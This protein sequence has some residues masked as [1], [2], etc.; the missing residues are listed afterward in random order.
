[1]QRHRARGRLVVPRHRRARADPELGLDLPR[2]RVILRRQLVG[3][4]LPGRRDRGNRVGVQRA[5]RFAPRRA[6]PSTTLQNRPG[7]SSAED[8]TA[9]A[10][11]GMWGLATG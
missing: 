3:R 7:T 4:I 10:A 1:W 6:R 2:W 8:L 9:E 11:R 5:R